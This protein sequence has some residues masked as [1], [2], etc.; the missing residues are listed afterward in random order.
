[1]EGDFSD[2]S[3]SKNESDWQST[4]GVV[5][6]F[7]SVSLSANSAVFIAGTNGYSGTF[8]FKEDSAVTQSMLKVLGWNP[9]LKEFVLEVTNPTCSADAICPTMKIE[10]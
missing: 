8:Q 4:Y 6:I 1:M 10:L 7:D 2:S 9:T 5:S 3:C